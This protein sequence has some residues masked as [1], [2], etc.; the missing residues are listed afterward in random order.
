MLPVE[1]V[2]YPVPILTLF[3]KTAICI[4]LIKVHLYYNLVPIHT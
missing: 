4:N 1:K 3:L 2:K